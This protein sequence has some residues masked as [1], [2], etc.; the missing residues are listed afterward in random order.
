MA[1]VFILIALVCFQHG[2]V[3]LLKHAL[4]QL[5]QNEIT[6]MLNVYYYIVVTV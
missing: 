6:T 2:A 5:E 4:S 3:L 1:V